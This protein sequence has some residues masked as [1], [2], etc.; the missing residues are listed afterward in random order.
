MSGGAVP[1]GDAVE[2]REPQKTRSLLGTLS[3]TQLYVL[4]LIVVFSASGL[5][6]LEDV[7]FVLLSCVYIF[8]V[9]KVAFPDISGTSRVRA[10]GKTRLFTLYVGTGGVVGLLLPLAYIFGGFVEGDKKGVEAAAPHVFLLSCQV[11]LEGLSYALEFSLP[12]RAMVPV[13]YNTKRIFTILDWLRADFWK[14]TADLDLPSSSS[15]SAAVLWL[16]FGWALAVAN[17]VFWSFNLFCFLIPV[18]LPKAFRIYHQK[19]TTDAIPK[20]E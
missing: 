17:L 3:F 5:V 13:F 11:F 7:T 4:V 14:Q 15:S 20:E 9:S 2:P 18:Y 8:I 10:Y 12:G 16:R 1:I 6:C 19:K